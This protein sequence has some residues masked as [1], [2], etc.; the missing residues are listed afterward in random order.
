LAI[1]TVTAFTGKLFPD[2]FYDSFFVGEYG[3]IEA[4]RATRY[5]TCFSIIL[6]GT[7]G[8]GGGL[9]DKSGKEGE[10]LRK[11]ATTVLSSVRSCDITGLSESGKVIVILPETDYF[12]AL[13]AAKK[14]SRAISAAAGGTSESAVMLSSATFPRDGRAFHEMCAC[15]ERRLAARG[16]SLWEKLGCSKMLPSPDATR[17]PL[18][19]PLS[20]PAPGKTSRSS[21]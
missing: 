20:T 21:S 17:R 5:N 13:V 12:G 10:S 8:A 14:L 4:T 1:D 6:I 16:G 11:L 18:T 9:P 15:A 3:R 19:T 7:E 2:R